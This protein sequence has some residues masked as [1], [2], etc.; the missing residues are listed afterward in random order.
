M[1]SLSGSTNRGRER[2]GIKDGGKRRALLSLA[3]EQQPRC[4]S[5]CSCLPG[6][7]RG[8][9][10]ESSLQLLNT[11][12]TGL[13]ASAQGHNRTSREAPLPHG[14]SFNSK[15]PISKLLNIIVSIIPTSSFV[16][17]T[18]RLVAAPCHCFFVQP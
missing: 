14:L 6:L 13:R 8:T 18:L 12:R 11:C 3:G 7:G 17:P 15:G 10:G 9:A 1:G 5:F 2:E 4:G 16:P